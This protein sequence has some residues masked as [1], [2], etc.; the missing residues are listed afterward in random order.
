M[1]GLKDLL[2]ISNKQLK[3]DRLRFRPPANKLRA[4][5]ESPSGTEIT[6]PGWTFSY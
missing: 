5:N 2:A 3:G 1:D 6:S 4:R